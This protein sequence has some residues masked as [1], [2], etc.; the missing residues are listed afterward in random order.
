MK[1]EKYLELIRRSNN[2]S[3]V[4]AEEFLSEILDNELI[5]ENQVAEAL[6]HLTEKSVSLNEILGFLA[7][8]RARMKRVDVEGSLI[9][10]CG[11]G[12]DK[13]GTFNISTA[14]AIVL[15]AGGVKMAKHGNRNASSKCGS[16]DVLEALNIPVD[17]DPEAAAKKL[18][19]DSFVFLFA[20]KYHPSLKKLA[21]VRKKLGFPTVFNILGPLLNPASVKRQVIG[22]YNLDNAKMIAD[23]VARLNYEHAI[24]LVSEDG[25]DEASLSAPTNIFDIRG[26]T[27][28]NYLIKPQDYKLE[29]ADKAELLGGDAET[30][31]MIIREIMEPGDELSAAQ[32]VVVLNAA[33]GFYVS[34]FS[35]TIETGID[36]AMKVIKSGKAKQKLTDLG[37]NNE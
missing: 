25:L 21:V 27:V 5:S 28:E 3:V 34:G 6:T 8:M 9:D 15:A 35:E 37:N 18:D 14:S 16:A 17:L 11:T 2:L 13:S 20:Q 7:A 31:A 33:L 1:F 23:V 36:M 26:S 10:N 12:G 24:V 4:E 22:T 30:N 29:A 19:E 32:R